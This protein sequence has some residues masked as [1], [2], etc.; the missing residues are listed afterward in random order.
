MGLLGDFLLG[1]ITQGGPQVLNDMTQREREARLR[2]ERLDDYERQ[3]RLQLEDYARQRKDLLDD[4]ARKRTIKNEDD[5]AAERRKLES[6]AARKRQDLDI[7]RQDQQ[8][9]ALL[10]TPETRGLT[11]EQQYGVTKGINPFGGETEDGVT[12]DEVAANKQRF[13]EVTKAYNKTLGAVELGLKP[14]EMADA[15]IK[16][17]IKDKL[18]ANDITG[19]TAIARAW[20]GGLTQEE[21]D[22][23][24]Q[25]NTSRAAAATE[26]AA[27]AT[28][29]AGAAV[30]SANR[31]PGA[32]RAP[33]GQL[34]DAVQLRS[35]EGDVERL[36]KEVAT[37][38]KAARSAGE[39][40]SKA[41]TEPQ[42]AAARS[43][44]EAAQMEL[45][46][47]KA[48]RDAAI[49][50]RDEWR[51]RNPGVA[52]AATGSAPSKAYLGRE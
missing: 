39:L 42:K 44:V 30:T 7:K 15:D 23:R 28:T 16:A 10:L 13:L 51:S 1:A 5:I 11:P 40:Q 37:K 38:E 4:E 6:D 3:R 29:R 14:S 33:A 47:A 21:I 17:K 34:T 27:A 24:T 50:A 36:S 8:R 25:L 22:S 26:T 12:P 35:L 48:Q 52:A 41:L 45:N 32:G 46:R 31:P 20:R 43:A 49:R 2:Q 18:D 9:I 19:A